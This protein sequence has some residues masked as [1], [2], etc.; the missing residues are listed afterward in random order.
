MTTL[1]QGKRVVLRRLQDVVSNAIDLESLDAWAFILGEAPSRGARSPSLWNAAYSQ[2]GLRTRM[3]PLDVSAAN[4]RE[5]WHLLS[6]DPK[7]LG[8]AIAMPY[9]QIIASF[10]SNNLDPSAR[11]SSSVNCVFRDSGGSFRGANTDGEAALAVIRENVPDYSN[12]RYLVLGCGGAGIAVISSLAQI[13]N[14]GQV[15]VSRR[16]T[17]AAVLLETLGLHVI[18]YT[19]FERHLKSTD[20]V[21][22]TT[23]VGF[24]RANESPISLSNLSKLPLGSFVFDVVYQPSPTKLTKDALSLG[25]RATDGKRMNL[26]QAMRS[27]ALVN[28][29]IDVTNLETLM[30]SQP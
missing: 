15:K 3:F 5:T 25:L 6:Q 12:A 11:L 7:V 28:A 29:S 1:K 19:N 27:F 16:G 8:G 10:L 2:L 26:L 13:L 18:P 21:I 4:I 14:P 23:S 22:N 17:S 24:N 9:K 30:G 20:V